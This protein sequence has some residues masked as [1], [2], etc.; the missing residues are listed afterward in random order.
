MRSN[1]TIIELFKNEFSSLKKI[2]CIDK[3]L[4]K[5]IMLSLKKLSL[6]IGLGNTT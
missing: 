3:T 1:V 4:L 6:I 5:Q 2:E